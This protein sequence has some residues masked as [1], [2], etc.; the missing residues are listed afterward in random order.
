MAER[1]RRI[2]PPFGGVFVART[3]VLDAED[4]RRAIWRMAHEVIEANHGLDDLAVNSHRNDVGGA[5]GLGHSAVSLLDPLSKILEL[6]GWELLAIVTLDTTE[7]LALAIGTAQ[8]PGTAATR[9]K[10]KQGVAVVTLLGSAPLADLEHAML[11]RSLRCF[12]VAKDQPR[13]QDE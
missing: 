1:E 12:V 8:P 9:S 7:R 10:E 5:E 13:R 3:Q 11:D 2:T 6:G 4:V